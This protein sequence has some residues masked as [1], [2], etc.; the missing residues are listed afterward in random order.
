M[1]LTSWGACCARVA[2][3]CDGHG[4]EEACTDVL[5]DPGQACTLDLSLAF[6]NNERI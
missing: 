6:A 5:H 3:R 1:E 4:L 2:Q